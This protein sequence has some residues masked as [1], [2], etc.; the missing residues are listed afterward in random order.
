MSGVSGMMTQ[1]GRLHL[2]ARIGTQRVA[3]D[4]GVVKSVIEVDALTPVPRAGSHIAGLAALRSRVLTIIDS[5]AALGV[6][7]VA[8]DALHPA[9]V[10]MIDG[11]CYGLL[12]DEVEDVV[13][14]PDDA[15]GHARGLDAG[16]AR[17]ATAVVEHDGAALLLLDAAALVAGPP[18]LAA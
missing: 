17:V 11:H 10:V 1:N 14:I 5:H 15:R 6:A 16:W 3:I 7:S 13:A 18:A 12:V 4:A 8:P 2:I 9:V